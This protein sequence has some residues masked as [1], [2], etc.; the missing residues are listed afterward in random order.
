MGLGI[1]H[2]DGHYRRIDELLEAWV[3]AMLNI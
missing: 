3:V 2:A 1:N